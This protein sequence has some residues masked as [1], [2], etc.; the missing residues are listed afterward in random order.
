M[1]LE[2]MKTAQD[3]N[4][5]RLETHAKPHLI[6]PGMQ[7]LLQRKAPRGLESRKMAPRWEGPFRVL[8][9]SGKSQNVVTL[10]LG[11]GVER[12]FNKAQC[13]RFLVREFTYPMTKAHT[14]VVQLTQT[15]TNG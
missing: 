4:W 10:D 8:R 5:N 9:V 13:R 1:V 15:P 6:L 3:R 7:V 11:S 14:A 2:N 12:T